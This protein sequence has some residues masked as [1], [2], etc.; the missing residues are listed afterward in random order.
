MATVQLF[1]AL[2][3]TQVLDLVVEGG[4]RLPLLAAR[5]RTQAVNSNLLTYAQR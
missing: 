5:I 1:D 2:S 4:C 3:A